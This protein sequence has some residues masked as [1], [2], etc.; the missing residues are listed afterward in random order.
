MQTAQGTWSWAVTESE[1]QAA[2]PAAITVTSDTDTVDADTSSVEALR[3]TPGPDGISLREAIEVTNNDPGS[4]AIAFSSTLS[5]TTITLGQYLPPLTGGGVSIEGDINGDGAPDVT[6]VTTLQEEWSRA[7]QIASSGNRL[8]GLTLQGFAVGVW[9]DPA[10]GAYGDELPTHRTLADNVISGLAILGIRMDGIMFHSPASPDCGYR[11][12]DPCRTY[13]TFANTTIT[14]NTIETIPAAGTGINMSISNSGDRIAGAT[15]TDNTIRIGGGAGM[16]LISGGNAGND[17]VPA[18]ISDVLIARNSIEG[19]DA[20]G[21]EVVAGAT[22]AQGNITEAV[23][24][25]DNRVHVVC[26]GSEECDGITLGAGTDASSAMWPDVHPLRYPDGNV[27]RN[28][29][30]AGNRLSGDLTKGV[31]VSAGS[32]SAA[33]SRNRV[34]D[35]QIERNVISS[36][37]VGAGVL[38]QV[39]GTEGPAPDLHRYAT[40][41]QVTG[42]E[43]GANRISTGRTRS[44][45][46]LFFGGGIVLVGGSA[47]S[48]D[49]RI[50]DVRVEKNEIKVAF[51]AVHGGIKL[52]GGIGSTARGNRVTC[53]RLSANHVSGTRPAVSVRSNIGAKTNYASLGGC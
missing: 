12:P 18:R 50:R 3:S 7:I 16:Q 30:V 14:G 53:V 41:N 2:E 8:H 32:A 20:V 27:L 40:G 42:V 21:L 34:L 37:I 39:G 15:V 9:I 5:G 24:V 35:V 33:G 38:L 48:R 17:G 31:W 43:I 4:Y 28:V 19:I 10:T 26:R 46:S 13:I 47:F 45:L 36:T 44:G 11:K 29:E 22:R 1:T 23:R 25:L 6:I 51:E 52:I 49:G